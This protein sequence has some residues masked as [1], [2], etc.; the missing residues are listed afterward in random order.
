MLSRFKQ[1]R[2]VSEMPCPNVS[3][4]EV[5]QGNHLGNEWI[6]RKETTMQRMMERRQTTTDWSANRI[7]ALV[8]GIVFTLVGLA[9]FLVSS[10]MARGNLLGLDVDLVHNV[11]H[12]V[13]G[14][15]GLI[16]A[17]TGWSR[18]FNQIFGI[19]YI[20]V[21]LAGL[22]YPGLYFGG[23]LLGLMHV[24]AID[25]VLHWIVGLVATAVGFSRADYPARTTSPVS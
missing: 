8:I 14:L 16:A 22:V 11:I 6:L 19:I 17:F 18:R 3:W 4:G 24:N 5:S 20:I 10:S 7:V 13:T 12:L 23:R 15:L 2:I 21:G 1:E 9:G 25:H